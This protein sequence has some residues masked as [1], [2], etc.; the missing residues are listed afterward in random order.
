MATQ[1]GTKKPVWG[2][3][4]ILGVNLFGCDW[5]TTL[6]DG[7]SSQFDREFLRW[8]FAR[9]FEN[10]INCP[11]R[12]GFIAWNYLTNGYPSPLIQ[13]PATPSLHI[14]FAGPVVELNRVNGVDSQDANSQYFHPLL[15]RFWPPF[16]FFFGLVATCVGWWN[17]RLGGRNIVGGIVMIG[18]FWIAVV[19]GIMWLP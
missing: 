8:R 2:N 10:E 4:S 12:F 1:A 13:L 11:W 7:L 9:I 5:L 15:K 18:G 3:D 16:L 19:G 17:L 14:G 6:G